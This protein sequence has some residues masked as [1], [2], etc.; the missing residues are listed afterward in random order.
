LNDE[1]PEV[2][3]LPRI[4]SVIYSAMCT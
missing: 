1:D 4:L 3:T 2:E